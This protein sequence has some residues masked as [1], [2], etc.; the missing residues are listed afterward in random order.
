MEL[1]VLASHQFPSKYGPRG[2]FILRSYVARTRYTFICAPP[3]SYDRAKVARVVG[4]L[5]QAQHSQPCTMNRST[6]LRADQSVTKHVS[7]QSWREPACMYVVDFFLLAFIHIVFV[8]FYF[9]TC[10]TRYIRT[11]T[12]VYGL[13]FLL[14]SQNTHTQLL[15][16]ACCGRTYNAKH[17]VRAE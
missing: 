7:R 8:E 1:W 14:S 13:L 11:Y 4:Y 12:F 10:N 5:P 6:Q 3:C 16:L 2:C 9:Y 17:I 15:E